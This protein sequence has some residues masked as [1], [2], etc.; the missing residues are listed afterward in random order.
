MYFEVEYSVWVILRRS[1]TLL[2]ITF[3]FHLYRILTFHLVLYFVWLIRKTF[4]NIYVI[5]FIGSWLNLQIY[6]VLFRVIEFFNFCQLMTLIDQQHSEESF[7]Y[8]IIVIIANCFFVWLF[9]IF[10]AL[11]WYAH[12]IYCGI[13]VFFLFRFPK[14]S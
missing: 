13:S 9:T 7:C 4:T 12:F 14:I 10:T 6:W 2:N 3:S 8:F 11:I 1:V 5:G